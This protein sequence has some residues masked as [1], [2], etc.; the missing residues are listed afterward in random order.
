MMETPMSATV[1]RPVRVA[2]PRLTMRGL[3]AWLAD[4]DARHRAR[5][6]LASLDD[7]LLRDIGVTRA[8]VEAEV[9]RPLA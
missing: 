4:L 7:H 1:L 6:R 2:R 5:L 9:R 8:D 3:I